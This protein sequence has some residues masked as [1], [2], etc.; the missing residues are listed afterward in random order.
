MSRPSAASTAVWSRG[1]P[2]SGLAALMT[3]PVD[4]IATLDAAALHKRLLHRMQLLSAAYPFDSDECVPQHTQRAPH[5][6]AMTAMP[7]SDTVHTPHSP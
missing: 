4:A 6:H 2:S 3:K 1:A 5:A 7:S